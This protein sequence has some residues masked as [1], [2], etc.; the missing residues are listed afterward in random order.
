[1]YNPGTGG[2]PRFQVH[3]TGIF[4]VYT[5]LRAEGITTSG[6]PMRADARRSYGRLLAAA[7]EVFAEQGTGAALDDIAKRAGI[8]NATLYRHFPARQDLVQALLADRYDEL[9][10]TAERLLDDPDPRTALND[11]LRSLIAHLTAYRGLAASVMDIV[12]DPETELSASCQAMR[13]AAA[14]LLARAQDAAVIRPDLTITELLCL[15]NGI[16]VATERQPEDTPRLLS[17]L[18]EGLQ[19]SS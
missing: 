4:P 18:I 17:L 3:D 6:K 15:T 9:R 8:G 16:A 13:D 2:I 10:A 14:K 11:W 12:R 19:C 5:S 7:A 1:M